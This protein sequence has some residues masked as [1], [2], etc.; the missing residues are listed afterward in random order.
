MLHSHFLSNQPFI[1]RLF[2]CF[3]S[4]AVSGEIC[5]FIWMTLKYKVKL[6]CLLPFLLVF[7]WQLQAA[8]SPYVVNVLVADQSESTREQAFQRGLNKIFDR[9]FGGSV[10]ESERPEGRNYVQQFSYQPLKEIE[11]TSDG[12]VLSQRIKIQYNAHLIEKYLRDNGFSEN[13]Q[14]SI[15]HIDIEAVN[16]MAKYNRVEN[17]LTNLSVVEAVNPMQ[18]DGDK[19]KFEIVLRASKDAFLSLIKNNA[20]L[21]EVQVE[22]V[23]VEKAQ[24]KNSLATK[25]KINNEPGV[26]EV[27]IHKSEVNKPETNMSQTPSLLSGERDKRMQQETN[28]LTTSQANVQVKQPPVYHYRLAP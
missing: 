4:D 12:E 18:T 16:S 19:A 11:F 13:K 1:S 14:L 21:L 7:P 15:V 3:S 10:D 17:Y 26:N 25:V 8:D 27:G 22:N 9:I 6:L 5:K 28:L 2:L 24:V 23:Q 20:G